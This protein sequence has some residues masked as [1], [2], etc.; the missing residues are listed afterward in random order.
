MIFVRP[1][2]ATAT[3]RTSPTP[4]RYGW[5]VEHYDPSHEM[6][7]DA[8]PRTAPGGRRRKTAGPGPEASAFGVPPQ[9]PVVV[10]VA[11]VAPVDVDGVRT[12]EVGT[13]V[14]GLALVMLLPFYGWLQ[15]TGRVWWIWTCCAG[16]GLGLLGIEYCRRRRDRTA[17]LTRHSVL[18]TGTRRRRR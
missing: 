13:A 18:T 6:F 2:P 17:D 14:W 1:G 10:R 16:L 3:H 11:Q 5:R 4:A 9:A 12:V 8:S 7:P 15:E